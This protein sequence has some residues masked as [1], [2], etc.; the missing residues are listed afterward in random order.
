[1]SLALKKLDLTFYT[2]VGAAGE[3]FS[4]RKIAL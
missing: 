3:L 4:I 1:M 2:I